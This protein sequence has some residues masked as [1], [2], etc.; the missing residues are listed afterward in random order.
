MSDGSNAVMRLSWATV[1]PTPYRP[2]L[3]SVRD[4]P[5]RNE[6]GSQAISSKRQGRSSIAELF[7]ALRS[8]FN[9]ERGSPEERLRRASAI[10]QAMEHPGLQAP[11]QVRGGLAPWQVR[12][13]ASFIDTNL[14][15]PIRSVNLASIVRLT[16]CHF[17]RAFRNSFGDSP[18][19]YVIQR[20]IERAQGLMLS[21]DASLSEI[22][23]ACGFADQAYLC[24]LF[25]RIVGESPGCWRRARVD[26]RS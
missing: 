19:E 1:L 23:F 24:R 5:D 4:Q 21:T 8:A 16:P 10:L 9:D 13:V 11:A 14:D 15:G 6:S 12:K 17:S 18:I 7:T 25:R 22:A 3:P 26:P 20:R 2:E